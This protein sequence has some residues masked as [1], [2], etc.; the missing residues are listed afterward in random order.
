M[1]FKLFTFQGPTQIAKME[2]D[3]NEWLPT[4]GPSV[5]VKHIDNVS[6]RVSNNNTGGEDRRIMIMVWTGEK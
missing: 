3:I 1:N 6:D 2:K 4:L 5:E